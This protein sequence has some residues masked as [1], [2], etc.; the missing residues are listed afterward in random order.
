V[1]L[2]TLPAVH[3]VRGVMEKHPLKRI[4][5]PI[6]YTLAAVYLC[7]DVVFAGIAA[8]ISKWLARRAEMRRLQ[9]WIKSLPP[10]ACLALLAVPV[11]VL[12]PVKFLAAYLAATGH[13]TIAALA[14]CVGELLKLVLIEQLF[15]LTRDRLMRIPAFAW[16][17][18]QYSCA[19]EWIMQS[20]AWQNVRS[21]GLSFVEHVKSWRHL[22]HR[23]LAWNQSDR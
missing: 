9:D 8:P 4:L 18:G 3:L 23:R 15:E 14:F 6:T 7:I 10:Y 2:V 16:S 12:E 19:K 1:E 5:K 21:I 20:Q 13:I 11:I 22:A 17:Y